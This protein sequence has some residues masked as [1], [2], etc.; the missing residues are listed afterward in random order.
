MVPGGVRRRSER[1]RVVRGPEREKWRAETRT[2][3]VETVPSR[4]PVAAC[5][6]RTDARALCAW[7]NF[8]L[9]ARNETL[10]PQRRE[11]NGESNA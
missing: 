2:W 3:F 4:L 5:E 9:A 7:H 1:W 6:A 10:V 8:D 11:R